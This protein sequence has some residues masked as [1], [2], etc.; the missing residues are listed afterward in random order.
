MDSFKSGTALPSRDE[1]MLEDKTSRL[2]LRSGNAQVQSARVLSMK[3]LKLLRKRLGVPK[4]VQEFACLIIEMASEGEAAAEFS[5]VEVKIWEVLLRCRE[6]GKKYLKEEE[7]LRRA[8]GKSQKKKEKKK[9]KKRAAYDENNQKKSWKKGRYSDAS[10]SNSPS[11]DS[12]S[13]SEYE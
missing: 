2:T 12:S 8:K 3:G 10:S 6:K 7:K 11:S 9:E 1:A 4:Y 5:M 13:S